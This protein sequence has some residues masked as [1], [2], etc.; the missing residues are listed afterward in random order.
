MLPCSLVQGQLERLMENGH[1]R[2]DLI[3]IQKLTIN[4]H[5]EHDTQQQQQQEQKQKA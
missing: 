5:E 4:I 1:P 3:N 2:K